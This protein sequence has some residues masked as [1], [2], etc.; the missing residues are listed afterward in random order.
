M[1]NSAM[2]A[3]IANRMDAVFFIRDTS[4]IILAHKHQ[5][6]KYRLDIRMINGTPIHRNK[7][8]I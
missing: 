8:Q 1:G 5:N 4:K 3:S 2:M 7:Q 6:V